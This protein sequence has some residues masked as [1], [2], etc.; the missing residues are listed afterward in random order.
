MTLKGSLE[1]L[2]LSDIFQ[3]LSMNQHTGTLRVTDGQRE[4]LVYFADGE[5]T[6]L[7]SQRKARL[8]DMLVAGGKI[9]EDDLEFALDRQQEAEQG[10][11]HRKLG[12]I[13]VEEGFVSESDIVAMV[14]AQIQEDIYDLFL[15]KKAD[16][17]FLIDYCPEEL[18]HPGHNVT[19]LRFNTGSLIMEAMRRLDE[20]EQIASEIPSRKEVFR[21]TGDESDVRGLR[22]SSRYEGEVGLID[23]ERNIDQILEE[24]TL[25]E[26]ELHKLLC[27]LKKNGLISPLSPDELGEMA[28]DAFARGRF[29]QSASLYERLAEVVPKNR[30]I[31]LQLAESL[32]AYGDEKGALRQY[33]LL[34]Q[35]LEQAKNSTELA[36]VYRSILDIDPARDDIRERLRNLDHAYR[37]A[38]VYRVGVVAVAVLS[39]VAV[40]V[41][42]F[43]YSDEGRKLFDTVSAL[44]ERIGQSVSADSNDQPQGDARD[45]SQAQVSVTETLRKRAQELLED[46][47][48]AEAFEALMRLRGG[49]GRA[50]AD[51]VAL[52]LRVRSMPGGKQVFIN[53]TLYG[54]TDD[55]F[56]YL[57]G[58]RLTVELREDGRTLRAWRDLDPLTFHDLTADF[59]RKPLWSF[60]TGAAVRSAPAVAEGV[61]YFAS[62]DGY[63]YGV[64][65][66]D[67]I[68]TFRLPLREGNADP[69][70]EAV[71]SPVLFRDRLVVG[72][73]DGNALTFDL[74]ERSRLPG[75]R[76]A[77][78]PLLARP[79]IVEDGQIAVLAG[80]E[81]AVV[82]FSIRENAM[83]RSVP[84]CVNRISADLVV[85]GGTLFVAGEDNRVVAV[86]VGAR[87]LLWQHA[88]RTSPR[89][90]APP[91]IG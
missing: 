20:W 62:L 26:F 4:R 73:L 57:P 5:I 37:R 90:H 32:K 28:E 42:T 82:F 21:F 46:G 47:R 13:L 55:V 9:S 8:G 80:D 64:R 15:W 16:F 54:R 18:K 51:T 45:P 35:R 61:V 38:G 2:N 6:L 19:H 49:L 79:V 85:A 14:R 60:A 56:M 29:R 34:A 11:E 69:F 41:V 59:Q 3:S 44:V 86:D 63:L 30:T 89:R 24:S 70:G 10:G 76:V 22:L 74:E 91:G 25:G 65:L 81:G 66:A 31:R 71:S 23:G 88:G 83:V 84:V 40:G 87:S 77:E 12:E 36:R 53:G 17:E 48:E 58:D 39:I 75:R 7:A 43:Q 68:P 50:A 27:E 67:R 78:R 33:E 1:V 72:T 52:P